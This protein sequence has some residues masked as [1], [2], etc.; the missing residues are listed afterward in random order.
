MKS[1]IYKRMVEDSPIPY[2]HIK[3]TE[4]EMGDYDSIEVIDC[5]KAYKRIFENKSSIKERIFALNSVFDEEKQ[6]LKTILNNAKK[7][8][9]HTFVSY[10]ES[11][12]KYFSI[13]IFNGEDNEF[14]VIL[15]CVN[16]QHIKLSSALKKSPFIAWIKDKEGKY[17]DV[18]KRFLNSVNKSYD[19]IIGKTDYDILEKGQAEFITNHDYLVMKENIMCRYED[20]SFDQINKDTYH[21]VVK[22]PYTD[23]YE[24]TILGTIG[25]R[26]DI[27]ENV[28]LRKRLQNTEKRFLE[29]AD[30]IEDVIVVRDEKKIQY[31][32]PAFEKVYGFKPDEIYENI[33]NWYSHWDS[34]EYE[35]YP[36][37]YEYKEAAVTKFK[38]SREGEKD[39]WLWSK[40]VPILDEDGN[41]IKKVGIIS[42][43]TEEVK[44]RAEIDKIKNEFL[45]NLSHE[46]RTPINLVLSSLQVL[47][48][49]IDR[50]D[51]EIQ[52][53]FI[54]YL[55][56]ID[57]NGKRLLKLVNNL[58][59]TTRIEAGHFDYNPENN[60]IVRC[61]EDICMSIA[62]FV[63]ANDLEI[64]FDTDQEEKVISFDR[65]NMERIILN[66]LSNA[67]KFNKP[68]GLIKVDISCKDNVII[69][70]KD[71]GIGI[72]EEK[73][74]DIFE[75]FEQVKTKFQ[76]EK[77]GSGIGLSLVK[78]L[79][80]MHNGTIT[81]NSVHGEGSEFII[82]LPNV[83]ID[84]GNEYI[85][86]PEC[87][88]K[89][90][91]KMSI[92]LSDIYV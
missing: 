62:S 61:V 42:D 67:I 24:T 90:L 43:I 3:V 23:E 75:R 55:K 39:K 20:R 60:D 64:I 9:K 48:L 66:L 14:H 31:T 22:W 81:V 4:N 13:E 6:R 89:K 44:T 52:E 1:N 80:E 17:V 71:S 15:K 57:Q 35:T 88:M 21:E 58:I 59:D 12:K 68:N 83:V 51:Y 37:P 77:E 74:N 46:L 85:Y 76:K 78:S 72:P 84:N 27:S 65:D 29:I 79:I 7:N 26:I 47:N 2:I 87:D 36:E 11:I 40:F 16:S 32:N 86:K 56:I 8:K 19:E 25:I 91:N 92:E 49:K 45:T 38:V 10:L 18:N 82:T 41:I 30:N 34:I 53:Y 54:K 69:S 73:L 33:D 5:N 63:N 28:R 70:I 50:L